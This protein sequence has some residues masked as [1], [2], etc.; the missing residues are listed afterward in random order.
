MVK[1]LVRDVVQLVRVGNKGK[2]EGSP[3]AKGGRGATAC[4]DGAVA[5][6]MGREFGSPL[7]GGGQIF[8]TKA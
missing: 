2:G 7:A 8:G 4:P 5:P 1:R 6:P 3:K